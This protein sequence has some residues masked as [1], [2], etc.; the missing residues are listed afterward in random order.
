MPAIDVA[1]RSLLPLAVH[2]AA[3]G[4][5]AKVTAPGPPMRTSGLPLRSRACH[6]ELVP[7][8]IEQHHPAIA[9]RRAMVIR[10]RRAQRQKA[11]D[12]HITVPVTW[13]KADMH[14][15]LDSLFSGTAWKNNRGPPGGS[16]TTS[17]SPATK[18]GSTGWPITA[19]QN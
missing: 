5:P 6:A 18:S 2:G 19:L 3:T 9:I 14:T 1:E 17:L 16:I 13:L 8:R 4:N 11:L 10:D 7:R 12:L 15:I